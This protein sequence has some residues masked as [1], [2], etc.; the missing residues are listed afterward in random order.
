VHIN[1]LSD[2]LQ[3]LWILPALGP[4][5]KPAADVITDPAQ[6]AARERLKALDRHAANHANEREQRGAESIEKCAGARRC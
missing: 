6:A 3:A 4:S 5:H 1:L 2:S